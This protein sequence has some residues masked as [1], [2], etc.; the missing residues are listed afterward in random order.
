M[1]QQ[2]ADCEPGKGASPV[3]ISFDN[4]VTVTKREF[5]QAYQKYN[6]GFDSAKFH[7]PEKY[8]E[9]L[10]L[11]VKF[12]RKVMEAEKLGVDTV[13]SFKSELRGYLKQLAQPYL[14]EKDVL[15][16]LVKE[17][18]DRQ[19]QVVKVSHILFKSE[20]DASPTDTLKA[21]K[22]ALLIRD[23]V[24]KF[25][26]S[27]DE[28]AARH[29]EEP[30]ASKSKGH[31]SYFSV[32][33]FVHQFEDAAFKA[34]VGSVTMP[35]R[36]QF[37]YHLIK[38]WDKKQIKAPRTTAHIM[39]RF[40]ETYP[41]KDSLA[42]AKR[43]QDAYEALKAGK[44]F[45]DVASEYSDDP[46]TK[47]RG[48][49]LGT[50]Y[51]PLVEIQDRKYQLKSGEFSEPFQTQYG[52]HIV[53]VKDQEPFK[54]YATVE[55]ELKNKVSKDGRGT[56]AE[57]KLVAR[58]KQ[59]YG[60]KINKGGIDKMISTLGDKYLTPNVSPD[61]LSP[62]V[63]T[64]PVV[65]FKDNILT[66]KDLLVYLSNSRRNLG[67]NYSAVDQAMVDAENLA[68]TKLLEYEENRLAY[69]YPEYCYLAKEY[70]DGIMLYSLTEKQVWRKAV[71]DTVGLRAYYEKNKTEFPANERVRVREY[72]ARTETIIKSV[73][74]LLTLKLK[75]DEVD[76]LIVK[77]KINVRVSKLTY[78]KGSETASK[79]YGN[80][81]PFSVG[82]TP[83]GGAFIILALDEFLPKGTKG[84]EE[85][86]AEAITKYQNFLEQ[87]WLEELKSKYPY[88][89][90]DSVFKT[91]FKDLPKK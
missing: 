70:R 81:K 28:M 59:E 31:L 35:I 29:S 50:R 65:T 36:S 37:G 62:A 78:D 83:D 88:K 9:Y 21:Y 61:S 73:D 48:G 58:L 51:I 45:E 71:D 43:I 12:R 80:S 72:R 8:R 27:F 76:S 2:P 39:V 60:Y 75:L 69:K 20:A 90:N 63:R 15:D 74:S 25:N 19:F 16:K 26:K 5:E 91:L 89:L 7:T 52:W 55:K 3:L 53:S 85:A 49:D 41:A 66:V 77:N 44:K 6:G 38:I 68:K 33:D 34:P 57:E 14:I 42:A 24:L 32:F 56:T 46:N 30:N 1:A 64:L 4:G 13:P 17:S 84:F 79:F 11:Y 47:A 40:G 18:Y 87:L 22:K 82:P 10:D 54:P 67:K 23:S 86:K